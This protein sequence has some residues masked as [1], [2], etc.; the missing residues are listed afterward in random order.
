MDTGGQVIFHELAVGDGRKSD[1]VDVTA[2]ILKV[3]RRILKQMSCN[4]MSISFSYYIVILLM[5]PFGT[6]KGRILGWP[7]CSYLAQLYMSAAVP[8]LGGLARRH[9]QEHPNL[10]VR[11]LLA[12]HERVSA[13]A[14]VTHHV[15]S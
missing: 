11:L 5:V 15:C 12:P 9:A 4:Y 14:K 6:Y 3:L 13:V 10:F 2:Q 1:A 7:P 8:V